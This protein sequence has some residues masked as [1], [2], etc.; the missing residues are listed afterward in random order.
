[1]ERLL[2]QHH[3][4]KKT[5]KIDSKWP[6][7]NSRNCLWLPLE[8]IQHIFEDFFLRF[9]FNAID[10]GSHYYYCISLLATGILNLF[11]PKNFVFHKQKCLFNIFYYRLSYYKLFFQSK[12]QQTCTNRKTKPKLEFIRI[13]IKSKKMN[14]YSK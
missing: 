12:I 7:I 9:F 11:G 6:R 2:K 10:Y 13:H 1:L 3:V 5:C 8:L 14:I 4:L